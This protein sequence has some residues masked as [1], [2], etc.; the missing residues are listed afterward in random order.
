MMRLGSCAVR[1]ALVIAIAMALSTELQ[2]APRAV[3]RGVVVAAEGGRPLVGANVLLTD[4]GIVAQ[5]DAKGLFAFGA[6]AVGAHHIRV[7]YVGFVPGEVRVDLRSDTLVLVAMRVS[8]LALEDVLVTAERVRKSGSVIRV[9][10]SALDNVQPTSLADVLQFLPGHLASDGGL[11][12]IQQVTMRQVGG[13]PN[14]AL[15]TQVMIDGVPVSNNASMNRLPGDQ[16]VKAR[17]V[18]NG[19]I[20][21]RMLS[22]DHYES[23][24]V[25][26]GI[27][28]ARYGDLNS[29]A[30]T[31]RPKRGAM[32]YELRVRLDPVT[33]L[34][35]LGKGF[36]LWRGALHVGLDFAYATPD[37]RVTLQSY[38]RYGGQVDYTLSSDVGGKRVD[39]GVRGG[40]IGTLES[41][42]HD[43]DLTLKME[44]YNAHYSRYSLALQSRLHV[45][46]AWLNTISA[47]L[48]T[49]YT[50]D[51]LRRVRSVLPHGSTPLPLNLEEG[52]YDGIYLPHEYVSS[53]ALVSLPIQLFA[54]VETKS[55]FRLFGCSHTVSVGGDFRWEK[56][57]GPGYCYDVT[58]PPTPGNALSS[59]PRRYDAVPALA[60]LALYAEDLLK[61]RGAWGDVEIVFGIRST[62]QLNVG[63]SYSQLNRF[64]WEPRVNGYYGFPK[65]HIG[66]LAAVFGLRAGWGRQ[67]KWPTLDMTSP[68]TAYYDFIALN[69]Y[70]QQEANRL[71]RVRTFIED[72]RN[73][74]LRVA[75]VDKVEV[76]ME[77]LL[78]SMR[79]E[80]M[81]FREVLGS[82]FTY[83]SHY[84]SYD[85]NEY[86]YEGLKIEGKPDIGQL[87][88][89]SNRELVSLPRPSNGVSTRKLGVEYRLSVPRVAMLQTSFE[90]SGAY[91]NTRYDI[92]EPVEYHPTHLYNGKAYPYVGIYAWSEGREQQ[93]ANTTLWM[94]TH[95]RSLRLIFSTMV[96]VVWYSERRT[97]PFDGVPQKYRDLDASLK[98][99]LPEMASDPQ[100]GFLVQEF[101]DGYFDAAR[102]PFELSVNVKLTKEVGRYGRISL[103]ANRVWGYMPA[104]RNKYNQLIRRQYATFFGAE[105]KLTI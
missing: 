23:V 75:T 73:L 54:R 12:Q 6:L 69:Y 29:G 98:P 102:E 15:G 55:A 87:P 53:Y 1:I 88:V 78:G 74:K 39:F 31:L 18:V 61:A 4:M 59:R 79:V 24:E 2:S 81:G 68:P 37:E 7:T 34:A 11:S 17:S 96:Q 40:F 5:T 13:D 25:V 104:Y 57:V 85:Y 58:R 51:V 16:K 93:R 20:D 47:Q 56:N 44:S 38:K 66:S 41:E 95:L 28:S 21:L 52:E 90:L 32:P 80:V 99:Y 103:F 89:V 48:S 76:G 91:F 45:D 60:P 26:R 94:H 67:S 36:R 35:Y 62:R 3:L 33:K 97:L 72:A 46:L 64:C 30:I 101:A 9:G 8:T 14:T 71:L 43:P 86:V 42:K 100:L 10:E 27:A 82:G 77:L 49:D 84:Y 65:F 70:S 19:G 63:K 92:S 50:K 22:T 83:K 105:L